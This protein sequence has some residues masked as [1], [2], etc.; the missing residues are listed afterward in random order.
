ME[1][2][3]WV[4]PLSECSASDTIQTLATVKEM[5]NEWGIRRS[6]RKSSPLPYLWRRREGNSE[7][8]WGSREWAP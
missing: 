5:S 2:L 3:C 1:R 7:V 8:T 4:L 6:W